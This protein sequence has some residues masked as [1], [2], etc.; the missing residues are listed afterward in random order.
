MFQGYFL[1]SWL[2]LVIWYAFLYKGFTV[3]DARGLKPPLPHWFY[4]V[5]VTLAF[6]NSAL[7]PFIYGLGNRSVRRSFLKALGILKVRS[8]PVAESSLYS[9]TGL[10]NYRTAL[11]PLVTN[12]SYIAQHIINAD[13]ES[14]PL[15]TGSREEI[16]MEDIT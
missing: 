1:F 4:T 9:G 16:K 11:A 10:R 5:A 6:G 15:V 3:T 2:G 12:P 8:S 14:D 13:K 7:N